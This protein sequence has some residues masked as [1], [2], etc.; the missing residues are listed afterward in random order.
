M[1]AC[2]A[3]VSDVGRLWCSPLSFV[4]LS[5]LITVVVVSNFVL[6]VV[7]AAHDRQAVNGIGCCMPQ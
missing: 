6:V 1:R 4:F 5:L 2:S 7:G 3:T